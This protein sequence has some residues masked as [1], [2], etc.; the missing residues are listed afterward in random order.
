MTLEEYKYLVIRIRHKL[1]SQEKLDL[2][3][4]RMEALGLTIL[5]HW[6][7][8]RIQEFNE[9]FANKPQIAN[10]QYFL[11]AKTNEVEDSSSVADDDF[12]MLADDCL[13]WFGD[14]CLLS[15][16]KE[17]PMPSP[18]NLFN[19]V[20]YKGKPTCKCGLVVN[21]QEGITFDYVKEVLEKNSFSNIILNEENY[22]WMKVDFEAKS[23]FIPDF[24]KRYLKD[25][26]IKSFKVF[27]DRAN[28]GYSKKNLREDEWAAS[29]KV[30]P[31]N[32]EN[33]FD[34]SGDDSSLD[35]RF[36]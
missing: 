28:W 13:M 4:N 30:V 21:R 7:I 31:I 29:L 27:G 36:W 12:Q 6:D 3:I 24:G 34:F 2:A 32:R 22:M 20:F 33:N 14:D 15:L 16:Q 25:S 9:R 5:G 19:D 8:E 10:K 17:I 23:L 18:P 35:P 26:G 11:R 1:D